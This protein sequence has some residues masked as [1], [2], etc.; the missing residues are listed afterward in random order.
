MLLSIDIF[1]IFLLERTCCLNTVTLRM[2][3]IGH[4]LKILLCTVTNVC[5]CWP[6]NNIAFLIFRN[7]NNLLLYGYEIWPSI[8]DIL[9]Q[10]LSNLLHYTLYCKDHWLFTFQMW[11]RSW[12]HLTSLAMWWPAGLFRWLW[13][14]KLSHTGRY[15]HSLPVLKH[16]TVTT[17][18]WSQSLDV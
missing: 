5:K 12:V 10:I 3:V 9:Y 1:G 7:I 8:Y 13:W 4:N 15:G 16:R 18:D 17:E 14:I 2:K 11:Q 6:I